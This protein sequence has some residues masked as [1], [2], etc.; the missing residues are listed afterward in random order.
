M[1][2]EWTSCGMPIIFYGFFIKISFDK[3]I[4]MNYSKRI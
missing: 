1:T 4:F 2:V 3:I